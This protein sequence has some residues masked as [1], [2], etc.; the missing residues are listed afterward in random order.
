VSTAL[1]RRTPADL[2]PAQIGSGIAQQT[3]AGSVSAFFAL[4]SFDRRGGV[5]T[6]ALRVI[7]RT[8]SMLICRTWV[9]SRTGDAVLAH[10]IL[11]EVAPLSTSATHVPL[12]LADFASFDRAIAEIAGDGV[13]C[14]VEA[15]APVV[16]MP[17]RLYG[18]FALGTVAAVLLAIGAAAGLRAAGPRITAF[19]VPPEAL[20]GTTVRA[21]YAAAGSGKLSYSVLAP[22]G[23]RIDGGVLADASGSIP[24][25]IPV[26][27][28]PGAYTLQMEMAG[29]FGTATATRVLNALIP[30]STAGAAAIGAISVQPAVAKPGETIHVAYA[31]SGDGGYVRL[32]SNDGTIWA[33]H[34][35]SRHGQA[36]LVIPP[37]ANLRQMR[38]ILRVTK[39]RTAV[40][41]M[42]GV[43]IAARG[44]QSTDEQI[45]GDDDAD[46]AAVAAS[47]ANGIFQ[48]LTPTV[49]GGGFIRVRV[50]SPRNGMRIAL[51][52][53]RSRELSGLE[54][55]DE[56]NTVTLRTPRVKTPARYTVVASFTDGFGQESIVAPVTILP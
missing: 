53:G 30:K 32:L 19:A 11:I 37:I 16:T 13:H 15:P 28:E 25:P 9:V 1:A 12:W 17:R 35:F 18:L 55:G 49:A 38:V 45:A 29:P 41:S 8:A 42:A 26:S 27:R 34:P 54:V 24:I 43:A 56:T 50:L 20:A 23:R 33:Q 22:D 46:S 7:N 51:T 10:P 4:E 39:G 14:I 3:L 47:A 2:Q 48:V 31:A 44:N 36:Q 21:E 6:Y 40:E 5:A 52:N